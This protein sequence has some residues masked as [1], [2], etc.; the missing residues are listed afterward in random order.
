MEKHLNRRH[1]VLK[2]ISQSK[3][4]ISAS[5]IAK[6]LNVS[7]QIIVGDVALLRAEGHEITA[8]A[9]GYLMTPL[10]STTRFTRKIACKHG[11]DDTQKELYILVDSKI[12]VEN[13][14][15]EHQIYGEITGNL[16][17]E[18]RHDVDDF[19]KSL[20][21]NQGKLLSALTGGIHLHTVSFE[22]E[23]HFQTARDQLKR[24]NIL[25][26]N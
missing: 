1:S 5:L 3:K 12:R 9:R 21:D 22:S 24:A 13:V 18:N 16:G 2:I 20:K 8:T 17:L 26:E 7:R 11:L 10:N 25:V 19:I 6:T 23:E 15:I 14:I 4:P